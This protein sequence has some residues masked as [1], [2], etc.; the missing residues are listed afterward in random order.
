MTAATYDITI[1][2]GSDFS[3]Q[4]TVKQNDAPQDL[5]LYQARAQL[6]PSRTSDTLTASFTC[7]LPDAVNGVVKMDLGNAVSS[8]ISPGMYYYDLEIYTAGDA[9]VNRLIQGKAQVTPETTR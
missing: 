9:A 1:D 5:S 4:F 7:S 6:R 8:A 2:Q 3:L